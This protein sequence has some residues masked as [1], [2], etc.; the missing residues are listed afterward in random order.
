MK[1]ADEVS[2]GVDGEECEV[3]SG[4]WKLAKE[5]AR[6]FQADDCT[7]IAAG[8]AYY[9]QWSGSTPIGNRCAQ[10]PATRRPA[11]VVEPAAAGMEVTVERP[12]VAAK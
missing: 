6:G 5:T 11:F 12:A 8:I 2:S 4:V 1:R 9:A 3:G 7:Y 10:S